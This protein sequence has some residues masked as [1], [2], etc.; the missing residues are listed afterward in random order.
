[1]NTIKL[2]KNHKNKLI[3][4]FFSCFKPLNFIVLLRN[5]LSFLS[6]PKWEDYINKNNLTYN[7]LIKKGISWIKSSQDKVGSGGVGCYEFYRW[8]KGYPEVTGYI[9]PT[10]FEC[11][12]IYD[13][14]DL[15]NRAIRMTDWELSI[16]NLDG[17]WEGQYEGDGKPSI[18]FNTGQVLRGLISSFKETKD[19]KYL[20]SAIKAADWI[21]KNQDKDGSW[22]SANFKKMKRVYDTYVAA[23]LSELYLITKNESYAKS[24]RKNCDFVLSQQNKNGWFN[25]AD[26][27]LLNNDA[28][29]LHTISYTIDGLIETGL[30]LNEDKY[31]SSAKL[32]ANFLL[33]KSEITN[34]MPARFDKKW[35]KKSNYSC[36]TGNAQ[37]GIIF[38]RLYEINNDVRYINAALKL[39]DFL[40]YTQKLNSI[41]K[42]R[43]GGITGSYPIWGM[44]CP[45]KYPSWATKYYIDLLILIKKHT[46]LD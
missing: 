42:F 11:F 32:A 2:I 31:I 13:D 27:T 5:F 26:N 6:G 20:N 3:P 25:N 36:L 29:V 24:C 15:K 38:L 12:K 23:P 7:S 41:G 34:F 10:F 40:A 39:A 9:I 28:P 16:Q 22:S 1:M 4:I 44:Y 19:K 45:L 17:G 30:N 33:H 35:R 8:T 43:N 14:I 21:V 18:V 37:L 46:D